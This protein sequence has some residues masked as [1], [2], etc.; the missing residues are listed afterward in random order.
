M[1]A[2]GRMVETM[3]ISII[4]VTYNSEATL[5]D[6]IKSVIGQEYP[7]LEYII[8]DGLSQDG[9]MDIV[10][11]YQEHIQVVIS[12]KD[13]GI[14]D[15][16]NKGIQAATGEIIGIINSDD[17]LTPGALK[18]LAEHLEDDTEV[19]Y[20]KAYRLY[21]DGSVRDYLP[22]NLKIFT[23]KMPLVHPATFVKKAAYEQYGIFNVD[24]HYCMDRA[25]LYKMYQCGAKF[26]YID[27][28]FAYYR[29]GG[30]SENHYWDGTL[31]EGEKIS[32]AFGMNPVKARIITWY[33]KMRYILVLATRRFRH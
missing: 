5:E 1:N 21:A 3:K 6:T 18:A 26:Q 33:K 29:M 12:E 4:T 19:A 20:G 13:R 23:Y 7:D 32:V 8:V 17:M 30:M 10:R 24:Y 11:K 25:V 2:F 15:A 14:S 31:K 16:F 9:T 28:Y 27:E 22:R